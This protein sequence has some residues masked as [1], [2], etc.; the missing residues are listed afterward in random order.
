MVGRF[1]TERPDLVAVA[2]SQVGV[3][4]ATRAEFSENG[5]DN[6]PEFGTVKDPDGFKGLYEMDAYQHVKDGAPT[7][8]C[9]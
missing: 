4:N 9:C 6:V 2:I 3:S 5:P 8:P 7:P 1:L